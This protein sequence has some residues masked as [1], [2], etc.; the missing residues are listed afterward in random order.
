MAKLHISTDDGHTWSEHEQLRVRVEGLTVDN[1][2]T[3]SGESQVTLAVNFTG[4]GT[5]LD[6]L[7]DSLAVE[8]QVVGTSSATYDEIMERLRRGADDVE[9]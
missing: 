1:P 8:D 6:V 2:Y 4:E 5:I 7:D 3:M 9:E